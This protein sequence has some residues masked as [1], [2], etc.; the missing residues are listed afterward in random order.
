MIKY[1][2]SSSN[3]NQNKYNEN[4]EN[5]TIRSIKHNNVQNK[6]YQEKNINYK[7]ID[8]YKQMSNTIYDLDDL[9]LF[10]NKIDNLF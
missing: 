8:D 2:G 6:K 1:T 7:P 10:Q 3:S 9:E 4:D 5:N